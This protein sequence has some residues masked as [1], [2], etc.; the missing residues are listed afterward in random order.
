MPQ[1][2]CR[3]RPLSDLA[4][5]LS[6][7]VN[8][9]LA[10]LRGPKK[11]LAPKYF[12]D[13]Q[14]SHLFDEICTLPEYYPT[15]TEVLLLHEH[16]ATMA[17]EIGCGASLLEYG[18]G[19]SMKTGILLN[20]FFNLGAYVP[21]DIAGEYLLDSAERIAQEYPELDIWPVCADFMKLR[22]LPINDELPEGRRVVFFPG[23]TI[24]NLRPMEAGV[25]L[26]RMAEVCGGDGYLIIGVDLRKEKTILEKAYND[27]RG[28]TAA[29]NLNVLN[30]L[31]SELGADFN[32]SAF[33][34]RAFFNEEESR[35]E[36]HLVSARAQVVN[37]A[38]ESI[39]FDQGQSIHTENSYKYS[40]EDFQ[41]LLRSGGFS[42]L[43]SWTDSRKLFSIH[44]CRVA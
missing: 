27:K 4:P 5:D 23:S 28:V 11:E 21:I 29:F 10:G 33:S 1:L 36:M 31:N 22:D 38:G 43:Q 24:G 14:G 32:V 15:R 8:E 30:R 39:Q 3:L 7:D 13:L 12:Y 37:I 6:L 18:S 25:L 9:I 44:F 42:P 34:H 17:E 26:K 40:M 16:A 35:I 19:S 20:A 2:I 41:G